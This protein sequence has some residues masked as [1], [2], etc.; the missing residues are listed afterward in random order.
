M[1]DDTVVQSTLES[2]GVKSKSKATGLTHTVTLLLIT[3]IDQM[4]FALS[5][6]F[7]G[8]YWFL[9]VTC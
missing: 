1:L 2:R 6:F 3:N 7:H 4:F 9:L 8:T 5:P